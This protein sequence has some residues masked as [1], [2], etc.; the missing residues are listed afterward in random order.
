MKEKTKKVILLIII[1]TI[2]LLILIAAL[3]LN[4]KRLN[5]EASTSSIKNY[6]TEIRYEEISTHVIEDPDAII[7][8]SNSSNRASLEYEKKFIPVIKKYNLEIDVIYININNSVIVDPLYQNAPQLIFYKK[9][10]VSDVI[11]CLVLKNKKDIINLFEERGF[12]ND[13]YCFI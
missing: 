9:S 13:Y 2:T 3:R 11:D 10:S 5:E 4:Q 1:C 6:L 7:F 8:V 12:I